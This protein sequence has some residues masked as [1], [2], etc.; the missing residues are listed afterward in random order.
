MALAMTG[1]G[2]RDKI[3]LPG[4]PYYASAIIKPARLYPLALCPQETQLQEAT[5]PEHQGSATS[6]I[7]SMGCNL[8][9]KDLGPMRASPGRG[10]CAHHMSHAPPWGRDLALA[11]WTHGMVQLL[12]ALEAPR[13]SLPIFKTSVK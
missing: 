3:N 7:P 10:N 12:E 1:L 9:H 4:T 13:G 6:L 2:N 11:S 5:G 8:D